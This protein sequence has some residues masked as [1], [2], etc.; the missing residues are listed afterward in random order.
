MLLMEIVRVNAYGACPQ[1]L[2]VA[3]CVLMGRRGRVISFGRLWDIGHGIIPGVFLTVVFWAADSHPDTGD[4][5]RAWSGDPLPVGFPTCFDEIAAY[6][7]KVTSVALVLLTV[8]L[9]G[10]QSPSLIYRSTSASQASAI[11]V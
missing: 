3:P 6:S 8:I 2:S 10:F 4:T 5:S 7:R 9:G 11:A 1:D